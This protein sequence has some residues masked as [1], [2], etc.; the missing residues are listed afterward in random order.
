MSV[1]HL[2]CPNC[3]CPLQPP[4]GA[5]T[6]ISCPRCTTWVDID[7]ACFGSCLSC[8]KQHQDEVSVCVEVKDAE[9]P[10]GRGTE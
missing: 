8:H 4:S 10:A 5:T 3:K 6:S 2:V 9:T 1:N 7:P